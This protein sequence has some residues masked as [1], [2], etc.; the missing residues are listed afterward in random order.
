MPHKISDE[1]LVRFSDFLAARIG[2]FFP[3]NRRQDLV[4]G[5]KA[6]ARDLGC[7]SAEQCIRQLMLAP[8][9]REQ[10]EILASHLTVGETYF[11]RE[12]KSLAVLENHILP[13]LLHERRQQG[14]LH[15]RIWVAGCASGEEAYSLAILLS[16]LIA[17]LEKW[18]I[19][20]LATDINPLALQKAVRGNYGKWSFRDTPPEII[21]RYFV[22]RDG[23]WEIL[24]RLKGLVT[25][26]YHNLVADPYPALTNQTNA[27]DL[28]LCRNVLMYFA[29]GQ[30]RKVLQ[31]L[32]KSLV[33]DGW[34]IVGLTETSLVRFAPLVTVNFSGATV[35]RKDSGTKPIE[36]QAACPIPQTAGNLGGQQQ[37]RLDFPRTQDWLPARPTRLPEVLPAAVPEPPVLEPG[38][39]VTAALGEGALAERVEDLVRRA[40]SCADL[41]DLAAALSWCEQAVAAN[42]LN[43]AWH[44]LRAAILQEQDVLGDAA[45]SLRKAIY[46]DQDFIMAHFALGNVTLRQGNTRGARKHFDNVLTLLDG[47]PPDQPLPEA[48]GIIAGR[49]R[50]IVLSTIAMRQ[51]GERNTA[52]K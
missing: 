13:E 18:Q 51:L 20:I 41:G 23:R 34:L 36:P 9:V 46:L 45:S 1:L 11:F 21:E 50:E 12:K 10:I 44:Y 40:R 39:G 30:V 24:P 19:H 5:I 14:Q 33:E 17:D 4:R 7:D 8:L 31:N 25:F 47:Y 6:A 49:L 38:A 3:P 15:L 2:L 28:I 16:R 48:E 27:M 26:A 52:I 22:R 35:Y 42:R 32:G 29:A 43:P 37:A